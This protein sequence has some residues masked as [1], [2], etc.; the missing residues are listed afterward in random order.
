MYSNKLH[1]NLLTMMLKH[2][3]VVDIVVCPG[4]RNAPVVHNL[5]QAS[6]ELGFTLHGV[7]D[8][9]SAGFVALG[10]AASKHVPVCVCVTSGSAVLCLQPAIAEAF[11][12]NIPLLVVSADRPLAWI[13]QLDGQTIHQEDAYVPYALCFDVS[14]ETP[15][16]E[17]ASAF[18]EALSMLLEKKQ[19]VQLNMRI[20]EPL[21]DFTQ[22]SLPDFTSHQFALNQSSGPC[23]DAHLTSILSC[24]SQAERPLLVMGH[25]DVFAPELLAMLTEK[26]ACVP[27]IIS[28]ALG[29]THAAFLEEK[30]K[31]D[32]TIDYVPDVVVHLGGALIHKQIKLWLRRNEALKVYRLSD[33]NPQANTFGHLTDSVSI[34]TLQALNALLKLPSKPHCHKQFIDSIYADAPAHL[35][36]S[37]GV[38]HLV[39]KA[40][41]Q[42][43]KHHSRAIGALNLA[44]SM[45]VRLASMYIEGG[46]FP[47]YCNRGTNGI[48]GSLSFG[49]GCALF[50]S[51]VVLT[52]IGDL[53]FFYDV[54]ALWNSELKGNYRILLLNNKRGQI[55]SHLPGLSQSQALPQYIAAEHRFTAEGVAM[56][57]EC[58]YRQ[59]ADA[60]GL[61]EAIDW[62]LKTDFK[63]P[64]ILEIV[65]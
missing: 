33:I 42:Y 29:S 5:H 59:V 17:L 49:V 62:L 41:G 28:N 36:P 44:N 15:T 60:Q 46:H 32:Q 1:I 7:T 18:N 39:V 63:R 57:F 64:A 10:I 52:I 65:C 2:Y 51:D 14:E 13:D 54:N 34:P 4:S 48:E 40:L 30:L 16:D 45:S 27:E 24:I 23:V 19:P 55:F 47:V 35:S 53:S 58:A 43:L 61:N 26:M 12:R 20:N 25:S 3:G 56:S 31:R 38:E 21:F 11:Y 22:P 50:H 6:G 8:E 37:I 9:R